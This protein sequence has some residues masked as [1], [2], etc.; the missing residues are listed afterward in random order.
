MLHVLLISVIITSTLSSP[1]FKPSKHPT[2]LLYTVAE[3]GRSNAEL[4]LL[5]SI[6][7]NLARTKSPSVYRVNTVNWR[8]DTDDS[9]AFWLKELEEKGGIV[10]NDTLIESNLVDIVAFFLN[11]KTPSNDSYVLCNS[12]DTSVNV[13]I[14]LAAIGENLL[15][16]GDIITAKILEDANV[17]MYRDVREFSNDYDA[18]FESSDLDNISK[19][20]FVFQKPGSSSFL[21]DWSIL[22]RAIYMQWNTSSN[23]QNIALQN[24][25]KDGASAYGWGPENDYVSTLNGHGV[26]GHASDYCKNLAALANGVVSNHVKT[27]TRINAVANH[28]KTRTHNS[29]TDRRHTVSFLM[30]CV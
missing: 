26:W 20:V 10:V 8:N 29:T 14:T 5:D 7:G 12:N 25:S 15:V 19:S 23:V 18:A 11:G 24:V 17:Q 6:A 9:Y 13:A 30:R 21:A 2:S 28:V 27:Y 4:L 1:P 16:A 22:Q 3:R